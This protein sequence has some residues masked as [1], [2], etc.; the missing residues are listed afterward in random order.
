MQFPLAHWAQLQAGKSQWIV[1][2]VLLTFGGFKVI[3]Y[4]I[5]TMQL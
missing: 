3:F 2:I 4:W 1:R 5:V